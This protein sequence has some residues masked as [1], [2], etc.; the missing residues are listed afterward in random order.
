MIRDAR[1]DRQ[2]MSQPPEALHL[3][4]DAIQDLK[5]SHLVVLDLRGL[6]DATDYF[7]IASGNS[8]A[9]VRGLAESVMESC[10]A[11]GTTPT[12]WKG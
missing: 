8:D 9:H 7:V 12:M 10:T 5:G 3:A 11:A 1:A 6:N 4:L 2:V